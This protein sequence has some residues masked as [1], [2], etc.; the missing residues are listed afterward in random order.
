MRNTLQVIN[1]LK[2]KGLIKDYAIGGAIGALRWI[3]PFFTRDLDIFIVLK[4]KSEEGELIVLSPIY[5]ELKKRG[6]IWEG[7]WIII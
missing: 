4:E 6:Y 5:E 2:E 7:H 1:E 3:E